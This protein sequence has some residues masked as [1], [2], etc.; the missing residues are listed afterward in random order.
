MITISRRR[1][2]ALGGGLLAAGCTQRPSIGGAPPTTVA[3]PTES[4]APSTASPTPPTRSPTVVTTV[5][6]PAELVPDD[7][8][9]VMVELAGGNDAVNTLPPLDGR[10]RDLRPTLALPEDEIIATASL[11]GHGLHPSLAPLLPLFD[12][13]RIAT[14]AGI[15]FDDPDRSHFVS[16]DRWVKADRMDESTGWLGRWLDTLP[17]APSALGATALG[18]GGQMLRGAARQGTVIDAIDAFAFPSDLPHRAIRAL[19]EPVNDERLAAAA[20]AAFASSLGA[21]EEFDAI[22]D[23]VRAEIPATTADPYG[24]RGGYSTGLAVAAQL[25]LGDVGARAIT[26]TH[27]NFDTHSDQLGTHA[28]LLSDLATGLAAFWATLDAA[29]ASDRVL[30]VTHS[31]FGRRVRE[32]ASNGCDHGAAGVSF[33][34]GDAIRPGLHGSIDTSDLLDGDLRPQFDPRTVLTAGLDWLGGDAE[35]VLGGRND[36]LALLV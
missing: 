8:V 12:A 18:S 26:V 32:N 22:A 30:L 9:L 1:F 13:G 4:T 16:T 15:G 11:E 25:I 21:V 6:A 33:V 14:V 34:M 10:Y 23:A 7:R 36:E 17:D 27:G 2:L 28:D 29:G 19:T 24:T 35:A 20:Q 31:E 5:T 3:G